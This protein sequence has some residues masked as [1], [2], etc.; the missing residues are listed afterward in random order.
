MCKKENKQYQYLNS[1]TDPKHP[2]IKKN[3]GIEFL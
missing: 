3:M 2:V 1:N